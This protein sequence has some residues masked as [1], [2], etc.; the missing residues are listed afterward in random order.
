[1]FHSGRAI[2]STPAS[3]L[4]R[5]SDRIVHRLGMA[6]F[7]DLPAELVIQIIHHLFY[8]GGS[9][10]DPYPLSGHP[11]LE[12]DHTQ[13]DCSA[14]AKP[15]PH[16]GLYRWRGPRG[17]RPVDP[18][19]ASWPNG[20][21]SNPLLP[22]ALVNHTFRQ[23]VQELLFKSVYLCNVAAAGTFLKALTCGSKVSNRRRKH[24]ENG[25]SR[26]SQ[27][28]RSIQFSW[29]HSRS[30]GK[31]G[32]SLFCKILQNCPLLQNVYISNPFP[33]AFKESMLEALAS[34]PLIKEL[35]VCYGSEFHD[36]NFKWTPDEIVSQLFSHWDFLETVEFYGI[37]DWSSHHDPSREPAPTSIPVLNCAI[38][39][40]ILR[41]NKLD[42]LTL[43][44]LLKSC[45]ESMYTLKIT[46]PHLHLDP[47]AFARVLRD[48]TNPNLESLIIMKPVR[49]AYWIDFMNPNL[50][51]SP[52]ILETVFD[53]PTTLRNLKT[54]S[55][56]A[57]LIATDYLLPRL[58]KSLVKLCM[59]QCRIS[60]SRFINALAISSGHNE[61]SLPNLMCLSVN[62]PRKCRWSAEEKIAVQLAVEVRGGCFHTFCD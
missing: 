40:L 7:A 43:S 51:L 29:H 3:T 11:F 58:P 9:Y 48:S 60:A 59:G 37:S 55:F 52:G 15:R 22:L 53:S 19:Q 62:G 57:D 6:R 23:C 33:L 17:C 30:T 12:L 2:S 18:H 39:T 8:A 50:E 5:R 42:E 14:E 36:S 56:Y 21:P 31:R 35:V 24:H 28:V 38:R 10:V 47:E 27:H 45:G 54:L 4:G 20:L 13:L 44:N 34:K 32:A 61:R 41:D 1:M 16:E 26:L 46:G 25:P 49:S